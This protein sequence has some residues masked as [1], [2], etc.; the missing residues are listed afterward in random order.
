M[1]C[2]QTG[3]RY[4]KTLLTHSTTHLESQALKQPFFHSTLYHSPFYK[5]RK[6]L[7]AVQ[8]GRSSQ[9]ESLT[10]LMATYFPDWKDI[11]AWNHNFLR[12]N[13]TSYWKI[14]SLHTNPIKR[15]IF[16]THV[17]LRKI[18]CSS[19]VQENL[20]ILSFSELCCTELKKV[21]EKKSWDCDSSLV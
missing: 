17:L 16:C 8:T 9:K 2:C 6:S 5:H 19:Q 13:F 21:L 20:Y 11:V 4:T 14:L 10:I 18:L 12:Y 1:F 7:A 3:T 15:K